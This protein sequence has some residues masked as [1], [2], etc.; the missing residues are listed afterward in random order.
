MARALCLLLLALAPA[1]APAQAPVSDADAR[2]V[3]KVIEAQLDAFQHDDAAR[4]FSYAAAGIQESFG[5]PE[6]FM[7]MVR[8]A[9]SVVYRPKSVAFDAPQRA[10]RELVQPVRLTDSD[11][12]AWIALYPML[13]EA[14]GT[15]RI[16]GCQLARAGQEI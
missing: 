16:G 12:H 13:R 15:W 4:A 1:L 7:T 2:A 11:G 3:R 9:Y 14:D 8:T 5:T 6:N 10:G